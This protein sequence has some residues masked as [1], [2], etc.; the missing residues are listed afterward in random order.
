[1]LPALQ[2]LIENDEAGDPM[3]EAKWVR[4]T[5][6]RLSEQLA[7]RGH[8]A[9]RTTV[10]KLLKKLGYSMKRN[11]KR[12]GHSKDPDRDRQ[13]RYIAAQREKFKAAGLAIISVDT[14]KKELVGNF[15]NDGKAWCKEADEVDEHDFPSGA[16]C[17][18]VP[19]GVY[20]VVRNTGHV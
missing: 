2:T 14:K 8:Q 16:E 17:K 11:R 9:S 20:D 13:F 3:G 1:I 12:Q 15:R 18:A 19:F 6:G 7:E 4:V 10:R 5:P